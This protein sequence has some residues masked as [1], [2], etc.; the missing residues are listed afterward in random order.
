MSARAVGRRSTG[1]T[2]PRSP[3]PVNLGWPCY[4]G[5]YTGV[6]KQPGWDSLD[7]PVCEALYAAETAAPGTVRPPVFS[8]RTRGGG[9][10]TPG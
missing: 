6:Q 10:L 7:K 5:A 4:E 2:C 3:T 1:P 9:V 8:Y